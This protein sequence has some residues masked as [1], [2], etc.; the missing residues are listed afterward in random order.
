MCIGVFPFHMGPGA[1][2]GQKRTSDVQNCVTDA[3]KQ[4]CGCWAPGPLQE[5]RV[6]LTPESSPVS[7][8]WLPFLRTLHLS[9]GKRGYPTDTWAAGPVALL[10]GVPGTLIPRVLSGTF[11][12][13]FKS[14]L[15]AWSFK[16]RSFLAILSHH[17]HHSPPTTIITINHHLYPI[18]LSHCFLTLL[19]AELSDNKWQT[20]QL[21]RKLSWRQDFASSVNPVLG[22]LARHWETG[23]SEW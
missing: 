14:L 3:C 2:R 11:F 7:R 5:Q 12:T 23:T 20:D 22:H 4:P 18:T 8:V 9:E 6:R 17:H 16:K 21:R 13:S 15:H 19:L 10:A 1:C